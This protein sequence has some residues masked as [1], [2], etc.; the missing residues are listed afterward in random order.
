MIY[1]LT[2]WLQLAFDPPGVGVFRYI[3]FR[4]AGAAITALL[5]SVFIGPMIIRFLKKRLIGE[6]SKRE[7]QGVGNHCTKAGTPTMGGLIVLASVL[8]PTLLWANISN[9]YVILIMLTTAWLGAVGFLDDYLKVVRKLPNGLIGRYKIVGQVSIGLIL[10]CTIYF[11]P[12]FFGKNF[13]P[14][15]TLTTVPF[16]K[17]IYFD[18][19]LLYIPAVVFVLTATS[20]A[21]NLT[22]GL[23]GLSIGTVG[24]A[25]LALALISYFSGNFEFSK[26][27]N[28]V[29]LP[30]SGELTI[31][32]AAM[33]GAALG[34]LWFNSYPAQVFM[35]DTGSLAL[36]GAIG[37]LC[38][39]IKKEFLLPIVGGVFF[40]ET[41]SVILQV[42]YFKWTKKRYGE[43]KRL[44]RMAPLHHHF[45]KAGLHE[46][47][48][49]TRFY[50]VA[51]I[52][53]IIT[54][55]TFKF[56]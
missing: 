4:S 41:I 38:I 27:L 30:G 45:E 55:A 21:V 53:A 17:H 3:T 49:V 37:G 18:F 32:A 35:G 50:I 31:F 24:I 29:F 5:I 13:E 16:A 8:L 11:F 23:D 44:F 12:E 48:I 28:I 26:Y 9:I 33:I 25:A 51:V 1:F 43:G 7:L 54:M 20:N 47:K 22:D 40:A 10:G 46:S 15:R 14:I 42:S 39:L 19:G 34:F 56:R 6:Q 36:G 52:L 2:R